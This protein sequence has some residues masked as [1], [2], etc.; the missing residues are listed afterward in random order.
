MSINTIMM[1]IRIAMGNK[2]VN[3]NG[4]S[5]NTITNPT[6]ENTIFINPNPREN[7]IFKKKKPISNININDICILLNLFLRNN[8][9]YAEHLPI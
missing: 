3:P 4:I 2:S 6:K 9:N 8:N 7:I 1:P 5:A